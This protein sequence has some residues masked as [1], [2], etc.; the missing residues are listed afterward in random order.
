MATEIKRGL[1]RN[2]AWLLDFGRAGCA[3]VGTLVLL[4]LIDQP[5]T[6]VLPDTP[7]YC[8]RVVF[9]KDQLLA[10]MDMNVRLGGLPEPPKL[11]AVA[12]YQSSSG[13]ETRFG[14][15]ML[16]STP[17]A[18]SVGNS[19]ACALSELSSVWQP[20]AISCFEHEGVPVPVL[21]LGRIFASPGD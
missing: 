2:N 1:S 17:V 9:W 15:L 18:V 7:Q 14:A 12:G 21:N 11:L 5:K 20:L 16:A 10:V 13:G 3:A 4:E 8:R 6:F 19:Q